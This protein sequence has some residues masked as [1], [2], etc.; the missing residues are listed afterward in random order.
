MPPT[1]WLDV[2]KRQLKLNPGKSIKDIMPKAKTEWTEI[3]KN[4]PSTFSSK[5][6]SKK[7]IKSVKKRKPKTKRRKS[8][9]R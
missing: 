6:K 1:T 2:I 8:K 9:K 7:R 4:R 3:K 5:V